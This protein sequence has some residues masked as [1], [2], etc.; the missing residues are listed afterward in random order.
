MTQHFSYTLRPHRAVLGMGWL[1]LVVIMFGTVISSI[2]GTSSHGIAAFPTAFHVNPTSLDTSHEHVHEHANEDG[3]IE[4]VTQSAGAD[5]PHHHGADHSHDNAHALPVAWS[6]AAPQLPGWFG[7][8][9][10]WIEMVQ[11]SRL[12]RPPMG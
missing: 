6:S 11:A 8:V 10:P 1:V 5:H 4:L 12:E 3:G 7:L 2:G 9:W